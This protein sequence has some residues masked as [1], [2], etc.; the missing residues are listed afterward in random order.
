MKWSPRLPRCRTRCTP[1]ILPLLSHILPFKIEATAQIAPSNVQIVS[2][3]EL[4]TFL[5]KMQVCPG[6]HE[7][8]YNF[9]GYTSRFSMLGEGAGGINNLFHS[10][11]VGGVHFAA[12]ST[13][14]DFSPTSAQ[15][16]WLAQDLGRVD[17]SVTPWVVVFGHKALY[18]STDDYYDCEVN[19]P[20]HIAPSI[21]PLLHQHRVDLYLTGHVH[22]YER[23]YPV[24]NGTVT[25]KSYAN[26]TATVHVVVGMAGCDEGLTPGFVSPSPPWS[27]KRE[28][29]LGYASLEFASPTEM[30]FNYLLSN[31]GAVADTFTITRP[32]PQ[33]P[34]D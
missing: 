11:D 13:E 31:T 9:S 29:Q 18:C 12:F 34:R 4:V 15:V 24:F 7:H 2:L 28:A 23:T 26:T 6:N 8:Y 22:N 21:E 3:A 20:L 30:T 14:H 10:F 25:A 33:S 16:Q 5:F 17:R 19:G 1:H 27:V 32:V